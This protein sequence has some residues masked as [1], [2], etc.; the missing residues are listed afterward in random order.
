[1]PDI[2][3]ELTPLPPTLPPAPLS[4]LSQFD[5]WVGQVTTDPLRTLQTAPVTTLAIVGVGVVVGV[6]LVDLLTYLLAVVSGTRSSYV[7]F[8]RNA[9]EKIFNLW[10]NRGDNFIGDL[11]GDPYYGRMSR[12]LDPTSQILDSLSAAWK[13]WDQGGVAAFLENS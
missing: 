13:K 12:S 2:P 9:F 1:M 11:M 6:L 3:Y 8:S 5:A 7:P 4:L 10:D